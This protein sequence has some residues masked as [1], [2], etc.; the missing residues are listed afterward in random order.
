MHTDFRMTVNVEWAARSAPA[1]PKPK[2]TNLAARA[3]LQYENRV[4]RELKRHLTLG[5]FT[6]VEHNPWFQFSD[7]YGVAAC[8]PDFILLSE[9]ELTIVEV[10]LTWVD[11]AIRKL[12][13]LYN[14]VISM[15]LQ[16]PVFPLLICRNLTRESPPAEATLS[17]ALKSNYRLLHWPDTGHIQW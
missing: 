10:K 11:V 9:R 4:D 3:G 17:R 5:N 13:D 12:N 14:P 7:L 6:H 8:S 2:P 16:R 1:Y 15:A